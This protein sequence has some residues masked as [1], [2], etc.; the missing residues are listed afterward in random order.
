MLDLFSIGRT[1]HWLSTREKLSWGT[2]DHTMPNARNAFRD[3]ADNATR[4]IVQRLT[5]EVPNQR[6]SL[7]D[8]KV[9]W[10]HIGHSLDCSDRTL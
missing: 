7:D 10:Q 2:L 9:H 3:I 8:L 4:N 6:A 1:I 5:F